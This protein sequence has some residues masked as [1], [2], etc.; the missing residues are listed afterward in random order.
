MRSI[1]D[2]EIYS[3]FCEAPGK[4]IMGDFW[5]TCYSEKVTQIYM[6]LPNWSVKLIKDIGLLA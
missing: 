5:N 4:A 2:N 3:I 6:L 1:V